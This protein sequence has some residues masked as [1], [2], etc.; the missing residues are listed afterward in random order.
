MLTFLRGT[1]CSCVLFAFA[2]ATTWPTLESLVF[3]NEATP[4]QVY[5]ITVVNRDPELEAIVSASEDSIEESFGAKAV[6]T[7]RDPIAVDGFLEVLHSRA[8]SPC[9]EHGELA[10]GILFDDVDGKRLGAIY[11]DSIHPCAKIRGKWYFVERDLRM[12]LGRT[13]SFMSY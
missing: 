2:G 3:S 5:S 9:K 7:R 8:L 12:Y 11:L 1:I 4:G 13:F 10:W 6:V